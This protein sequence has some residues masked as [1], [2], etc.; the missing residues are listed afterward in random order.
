[1]EEITKYTP[2][3]QE[4]S[5]ATSSTS[6]TTVVEKNIEK[7]KLQFEFNRN[8]LILPFQG[9]YLSF[10]EGNMKP[11]CDKTLLSHQQIYSTEFKNAIFTIFRD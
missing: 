9:F 10:K 6:A 1:M 2:E 3:K 8:E 11:R 5:S 4:E 7:N